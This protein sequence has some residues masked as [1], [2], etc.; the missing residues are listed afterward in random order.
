MDTLPRTAISCPAEFCVRTSKPKLSKSRLAHVALN[1]PFE[2]EAKLPGTVEEHVCLSYEFFTYPIDQQD[3][4][5][6]HQQ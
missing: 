5:C 2:N 3:S 4:S 6:H 1:K